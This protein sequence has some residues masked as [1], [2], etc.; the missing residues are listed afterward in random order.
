MT[1]IRSEG[2]L[3]P[4]LVYERAYREFKKTHSQSCQD[5]SNSSVLSHWLSWVLD[6]RELPERFLLPILRQ[7]I[8]PGKWIHDCRVEL[9]GNLQRS[10]NG[11]LHEATTNA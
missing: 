8:P 5:P 2:F 6:D 9:P 3:V 10:S 4:V 11:P 7:R 1:W